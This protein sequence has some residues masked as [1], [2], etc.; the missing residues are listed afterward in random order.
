MKHATASVATT[1]AQILAQDNAREYLLIQNTSDTAVYIKFN[2]A[3][4]AG[5]G[6]MLAPGDAYEVYSALLGNSA[7]NYVSAIH[8]GEGNKT[9]L[10][11]ED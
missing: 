1:A 9:L 6:V 4:V 11:S 2:E 3:A 10:I 5:E 7:A 8:G